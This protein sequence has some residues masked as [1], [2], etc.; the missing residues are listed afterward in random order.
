MQKQQLVTKCNTE[1][2]KSKLYKDIDT[3]FQLDEITH[4][5][6]NEQQKRNHIDI[7]VSII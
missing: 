2:I 1:I 3:C 5:P 4:T 6:K 7:K